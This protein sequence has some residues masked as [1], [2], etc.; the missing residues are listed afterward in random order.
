MATGS[1]AISAINGDNT[2]TLTIGLNGGGILTTALMANA[3][4]HAAAAG[5]AG[6]AEKLTIK[7]DSTVTSIDDDVMSVIGTHLSDQD[8][9][10]VEINMFDSGVVT[11]QA[12]T[13]KDLTDL[14]QVSFSSALTT[15]GATAFSGCTSLTEILFHSTGVNKTIH[16]TAFTNV[17]LEIVNVYGGTQ[18]SI[19]GIDDLTTN[20]TRAGTFFGSVDADG[21]A[22]SILIKAFMLSL[23]VQL[24]AL[25]VSALTGNVSLFSAPIPIFDN[26]DATLT[27][28]VS[29]AGVSQLFK[30]NS[31][32]LIDEGGAN[33]VPT[34][35]FG[36]SAQN[37]TDSA[38]CVGEYGVAAAGAADASSV[39]KDSATNT[40]RGRAAEKW[41]QTLA[42][43]M[44]GSTGAVD[45]IT[46]ENGTISAFGDAIDACSTLVRGKLSTSAV[47]T[48]SA[49]VYAAL[50]SK[51]TT[52]NRF[53]LK[54]NADVN[55]VVDTGLY[56]KDTP[57]T[58][59][60]CVVAN[61]AT[62]GGAGAGGKATVVIER[63]SEDGVAPAVY[64]VLSIVMVDKVTADVEIGSA[65]SFTESAG[66]VILIGAINSVQAAMI[67]DTLN[68]QTSLPFE[69]GDK[70]RLKYGVSSNGSQTN[71]SG[72]NIS[73]S[74]DV[75]VIVNVIA[76]P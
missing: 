65:V 4:G 48:A 9:T 45:M 55:S 1:Y 74:I 7:L 40:A 5:T 29:V 46:N 16:S 24:T 17:P 61:T 21:N 73:T 39:L 47:N 33:N 25:A 34:F 23:D 57:V 15:I 36:P 6:T 13:F 27:T 49:D 76:D 41:V 18:L 68:T 3:I 71:I 54:Y 63:T 52:K 28:T 62:D 8:I 51:E 69:I 60:N 14:K 30:F 56:A 20:S 12:D 10:L 2:F 66:P 50:L 70:L 38:F 64:K 53:A 67:N 35:N 26:V 37:I 42:L 75:G 11:V 22:I 72:D 32:S 31:D 19:T 59:Y 44:F 58:I 43:S